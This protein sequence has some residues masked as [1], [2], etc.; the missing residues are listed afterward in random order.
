MPHKKQLKYK[1]DQS[2]A[3]IGV[4]GLGYV[5]LPLAAEIAN[6]GFRVI[7][8]DID[9]ERVNQVSCGESYIL[10]LPS[11]ELSRLTKSKQLTATVDYSIISE[12]DVIIV[13]VPTPLGKTKTPDISNIVSAVE[14]VSNFLRRDQLV[15][16]EST[17]YPGTTDEVVRPILENTGL[18][19]GKDFYLAFSPERIDPGNKNYHTGNT[20]KIVGGITDQCTKLAW[21][22]YQKFVDQVYSVSNSQT[23]ET[24]KLL[25]NTF[26]AVNIALANEFSQMC[27]KMGLDVWEIIDAAA[28]KPF[29]F[30]PFYPGPGLGGHCIPVDPHYLAWKAQL[31]GHDS[32]L[33]D[34][35][36]TINA[37]MPTYIVNKVKKQ[38]DKM[39]LSIQRSKIL[40]IGMSYKPNVSD[41]RESPSVEIA[42]QLLAEK[43]KIDYHDPFVPEVILDNQTYYSK[44]LSRQL[45]GNADC[46]LIATDHDN[47]D[48]KL[49]D[50]FNKSIVD[51]RNGL[52]KKN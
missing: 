43:A 46:C 12:L 27:D 5:G 15:V 6:S 17:T 51:P 37:S 22:F 29:G 8:I 19:V 50:Q 16:L 33:I 30:M 48:Y 32:R 20:P 31:H 39:G 26:R 23:A 21:K 45:I 47:I 49:I 52:Q 2:L 4:L 7:G 1:I 14:S 18:M 10:D 36:S 11:S 41:L 13:C 3:G 9:N 24:V 44:E 35:A 42:R 28:T 25:E 34:L 40:I 38:L